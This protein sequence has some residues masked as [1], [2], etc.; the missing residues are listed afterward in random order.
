MTNVSSIDLEA[1]R[2]GG[3]DFLLLDIRSKEQ[4]DDDHIEGAQDVPLDSP[5]FLATV[6]RVAGGKSRKIVVYGSE[7][8]S[9]AAGRAAYQLSAVGFTDVSSYD[10]GLADWRHRADVAAPMDLRASMA[11]MSGSASEIS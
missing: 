11:P 6:A 1:L 4:F 8:A 3:A 10:G 5:D 7:L 2:H 9:D